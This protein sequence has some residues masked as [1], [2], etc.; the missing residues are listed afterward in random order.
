[1]PLAARAAADLGMQEM[2]QSGKADEAVRPRQQPQTSKQRRTGDAARR[3]DAVGDLKRHE[4]TVELLLRIHAE[5]AR[6]ARHGQRDRRR[7]GGRCLVA[8]GAQCDARDRPVGLRAFKAQV[9]NKGACA[10]L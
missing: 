9:M 2:Q 4:G 5:R 8:A 7:S 3:R 6:K 1:M 10:L